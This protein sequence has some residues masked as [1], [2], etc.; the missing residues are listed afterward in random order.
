[1]EKHLLWTA[2]PFSPIGYL[3]VNEQADRCFYFYF[4]YFLLL[5]APS[6]R[7]FLAYLTFSLQV[8]VQVQTSA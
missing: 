2:R 1:M 7:F 5:I 4:R 3:S 8:Q 6:L